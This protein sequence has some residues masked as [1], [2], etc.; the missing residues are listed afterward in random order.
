[1]SCSSG[2][3]ATLSLKKWKPSAVLARASATSFSTVELPSRHMGATQSRTEL[4][5]V[6]DVTADKQRRPVAPG[7]NEAALRVACHGRGRGGLAPAHGAVSSLDAHQQI[8]R[9]PNDD[10]RHLDGLLQRQRD[11]NGLDMAD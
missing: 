6:P 4:R 8:F 5:P 1:M 10:A 9:V 3:V 11:W 2:L 7:R